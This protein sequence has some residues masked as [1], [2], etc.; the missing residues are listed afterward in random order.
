MVI[1][2]LTGVPFADMRG[3]KKVTKQVVIGPDDGSAEMIMRYFSVAPGGMTPH[4]QHDFPHVVQVQRGAGSAT[5]ESGVEHPLAAGD[6]VYVN[7][8]EIHHF[9]NTGDEP[10]DFICIVPAR[11]EA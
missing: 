1:K 8:G 10:F 2:K 4:H 7:S 11:G 5:D 6:Y 9:T 3:Y